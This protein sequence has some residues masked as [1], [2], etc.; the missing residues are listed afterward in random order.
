MRVES[1]KYPLPESAVAQEAIEPRHASR[2]LDTRDMS[3]HRFLDLPSLLEPGDLVVV[4]ETRVRSARLWGRRRDTG[5]G[6]ELLVL[7]ARLDGLWNALARP[8]RRLRPGVE[9][10][11][12]GL[13]ASVVE[14]PEGGVVVVDMKAPD[15]EAAIAAAGTT[16]LPPYFHGTLGDPD[17]YQTMFARTTGSA[18]APTA[19]LHFTP[20]VAAGLEQ[21]GIEIASVDLHVGIDTFRPI[22]ADEIEQHVMHS[23]WCSISATTAAAISRTRAGGGRVVAV[24][25]T[26]VRTLETF[27]ND[28]RTVGAG[29]GETDL[30]LRPGDDFQ[31]VDAMVTNFH[32]PGSTLVVLVAAFMGERWRE[33]YQTALDR[34]YRFLSFGDAMYAER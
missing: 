33:A 6:I 20:A 3:D 12:K 5:G 22:T 32:V 17:R 26:V 14:G 4:N 30:F 16:P 24:G 25:T 9:I 15:V 10:E 18:A 11:M 28:D 7:E 29:E 27:A 2:L 13:I 31:V 21:Q 19:G 34:G 23:E 1:F 8:S